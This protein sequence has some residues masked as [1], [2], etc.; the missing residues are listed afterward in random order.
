MENQC[1][2]IEFPDNFD[3]HSL[4]PRISAIGNSGDNNKEAGGEKSNK[5]NEAETVVLSGVQAV[6]HNV[7]EM[8]LEVE[9]CP[10]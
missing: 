9:V 8:S 10:C 1:H 7:L 3:Y 2:K 6:S 4:V 5:L